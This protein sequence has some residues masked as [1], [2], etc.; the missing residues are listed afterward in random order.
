[1]CIY[2][3]FVSWCVH[4]SELSPLCEGSFTPWVVIII[5]NITSTI[6]SYIK[7]MFLHHRQH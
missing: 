5:I 4:G 1:M 6:L 3:K 2:N 7:V